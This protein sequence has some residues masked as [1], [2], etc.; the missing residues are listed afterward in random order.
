M[1]K[2]V[3]IIT[4]AALYASCKTISMN[5][6]IPDK[7]AAN[8]T[9]MKI[10]GLH[11]MRIKRHLAFGNYQVSNVKNGWVYTT[12]THDRNS[13]ITTEERLL[14]V[15]KL[16]HENA[17]QNTRN[18]YQYTIQDGDG[19]AEV[20][21][22]EKTTKEAVSSETPLGTFSKTKN[23]QYSFSAAIL[24]QTI[25]D[26]PWQLVFYSSYDSKKDTAHKFWD[27]PYVAHE[28][29]VTNGTT[30]INI[31]PIITDKVVTNDG[32]ELKTLA[33]VLMA[34]ELNIDGGVIGIVDV[35]KDNIWIYNDLDKDMK[36]IVAAVSSAILMRKLDE[37]KAA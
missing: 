19:M 13:G 34:Y 25:K 1:R 11:G 36:L 18:K 30:R 28:G 32:R 8:A 14:K 7:F 33:K 37:S 10:T 9:Q 31:R 12:G 20:Y 27:Q 2:L 24:P 17:T 22:M 5:V 29:Y 16:S 6:G 15:F 4:I 35:F 23:Y 3:V 26:E 21:C